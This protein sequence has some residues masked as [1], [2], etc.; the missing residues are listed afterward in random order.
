[1]IRPE[2]I[3]SFVSGSFRSVWA[4]E[5]LLLLKRQPGQ[6]AV[7]ELVGMLRASDLVVRQ[8]LHDLIAAGLVA[9]DEA[10]RANFA[11]ASADLAA[12]ADGAQELYARR[13]DAV[14]RLI[15]SGQARGLTAFADAFRLRKD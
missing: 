3:T 1:M 14:R 11:P 2:E 10:G 15:V 12:L 7:T 6:H 8:A 5:L 4:L 9:V 13:P